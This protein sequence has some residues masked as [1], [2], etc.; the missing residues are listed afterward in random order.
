[1]LHGAYPPTSFGGWCRVAC[2][3][4]GSA[5]EEAIVLLIEIATWLVAA[6]LI[7]G[8][9]WYL[10]GR[11]TPGGWYLLAAAGGALLG[12]TMA[13][14]SGSYWD[15]SGYSVSSLLVALVFALAAMVVVDV[16]TP[17]RHAP[18]R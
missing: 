9:E 14:I 7:A 16:F 2:T 8:L 6:A 12:G 10:T 17:R 1:M 3:L 18:R 5:A 4:Q 15:R 11:R 13:R